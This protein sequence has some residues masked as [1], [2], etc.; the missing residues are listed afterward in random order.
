[1]EHK[2]KKGKEDQVAKNVPFKGISTNIMKGI[3]H[4]LKTSWPTLVLLLSF[5][6]LQREQKNEVN[7]FLGIFDLMKAFY[8]ARSP[9]T[10]GRREEKKGKALEGKHTKES[11][12][13]LGPER[14]LKSLCVKKKGGRR[15]KADLEMLLWLFLLYF[16]LMLPLRALS[17]H[18]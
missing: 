11:W 16:S 9:F 14:A 10:P 8:A 17:F 3:L 2:G 15:R 13:P 4:F 6:L 1:M 5:V 12:L 18:C 7:L